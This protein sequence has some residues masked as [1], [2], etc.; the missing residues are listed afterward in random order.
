MAL[1]WHK[2][3]HEMVSIDSGSDRIAAAVISYGGKRLIVAVYMPVDY[4]DLK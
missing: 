1:L 2:H 4:G 3:M